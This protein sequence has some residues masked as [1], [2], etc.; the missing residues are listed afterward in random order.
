MQASHAQHGA[1][2]V[3]M[4]QHDRCLAANDAGGAGVPLPT[5]AVPT[6]DWGVAA[7][8]ASLGP[9]VSRD[10]AAAQWDFGRR[11]PR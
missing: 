6:H 2:A 1:S 8:G 10:D 11:R 5:A 9:P 7:P 3:A 4:P